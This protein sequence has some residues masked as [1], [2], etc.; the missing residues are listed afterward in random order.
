MRATDRASCSAKKDSKRRAR[1]D[2]DDDSDDSDELAEHMRKRSKSREK[3]IHAEMEK[4]K[5]LKCDLDVIKASNEEAEA[6]IVDARNDYQ[7]LI[8]NV[9]P[10]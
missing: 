10:K 5:K 8:V 9:S 1:L 3:E 6:R 2:S 7:V 4:A